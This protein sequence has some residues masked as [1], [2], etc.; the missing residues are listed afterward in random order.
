MT[1]DQRE[2]QEQSGRF[3]HRERSGKVDKWEKTDGRSYFLP[4]GFHFWLSNDLQHRLLPK[5]KLFH[6]NKYII[7]LSNLLYLMSK[8]T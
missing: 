6:E 4:R 1:L 8:K 2:K 7:T 5:N 3:Q